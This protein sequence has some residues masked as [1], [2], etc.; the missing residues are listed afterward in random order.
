MVTSHQFGFREKH[1]TIDQVHRIVH[2]IEETL[3]KKK[4]C[5]AIFLDV[6]Q[7]F[8]KVWHKGLDYKL[9]TQL[10]I[11]YTEI[12]ESYMNDRYF[13]VKQ[14]QAYSK[15][16]KIEAGVP[17]GSILGP[18]LYLL[19]TADIPLPFNSKIATFADDTCIL[20][21]GNDVIESTRKLQ[22]SV[23]K[24]VAWT[25]TWRIKLNEG[26]SVHVD[27][28][29]KSIQYIPIEISSFIVPHENSAKYLGMTLDAR[30]NW[31][32]HIKKKQTELNLKYK[33]L[34]W[35]IGRNS[36]VTTANKLLIY[37]QIIKPV[38]TY[39]SQLWGCAAKTYIETI[40]RIQ[41]KI[42]RDIVNAPWYARNDDIHRDL[43]VNKVAEAI[44]QAATNHTH[45]LQHHINP[46]ASILCNE[47]NYSRRLRRTKPH[48]LVAIINV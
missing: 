13:R 39:G 46:E 16:K 2:T 24:I 28:T 34:K 40:Q 26:K 47:E 29:N 37:N 3:E 14:G 9:K 7:A 5:S 23:N 4:V 43:G 17:Q 6:A 48:D 10:P 18:I 41:N 11:Q 30:L 21:T 8:D 44:K 15:L 45:R 19:Y 22:A 20:S 38:W 27:F 25:E 31:K 33:K 42:L 32:E 1:S 36:K 35:I 12:L